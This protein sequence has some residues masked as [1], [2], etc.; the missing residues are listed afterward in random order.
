MAWKGKLIFLWLLV[1]C[2]PSYLV[3]YLVYYRV[4]VRAFLGGVRALAVK[5]M[6]V[7]TLHR[8]SVAGTCGLLWVAEHDY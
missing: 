7:N 3:F 6:R 2:R 8:G 5:S 1:F 4:F